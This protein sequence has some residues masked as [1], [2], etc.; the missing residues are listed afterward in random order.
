[1][2]VY[3]IRTAKDCKRTLE[4]LLA[5]NRI[6]KEAMNRE[7]IGRIRNAL[8]DYYKHGDNK[9]DAMSQVEKAFFFS[10]IHESY[11]KAPAL[12]SPKTWNQ[13]LDDIEDYLTYY[14][15]LLD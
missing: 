1:M 10:A 15:R 11:V 14:L 12:N 4:E 13:G 6:A 9:E 2:S 8:R 5:L 7:T 3:G